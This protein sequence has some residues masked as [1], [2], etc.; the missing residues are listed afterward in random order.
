MGVVM[1]GNPKEENTGKV[2]L[3]TLGLT[4]NVGFGKRYNGTII[5]GEIHGGASGSPVLD[6]NGDVIGMV[7]GANDK[8][9]GGMAVSISTLRLAQLDTIELHLDVKPR[10]EIARVDNSAPA[11]TLW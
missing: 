6:P 3:G 7:W 1:I 2:T 9:T 10:T 8:E 4:V 5:N 11:P